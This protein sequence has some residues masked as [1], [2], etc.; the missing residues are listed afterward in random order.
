MDNL[1]A[2]TDVSVR[3][4]KVS[5]LQR[6]VEN[7]QQV[8]Q[9]AVV[10]SG[11]AAYPMIFI[12]RDGPQQLDEVITSVEV[13]ARS[14][15]D[16]QPGSSSS[17]NESASCQHET[18]DQAVTVQDGINSEP[19]ET[20][21]VENVLRMLPSEHSGP[22]SAMEMVQSESADQQGGV[23][24]FNNNRRVISTAICTM[25]IGGSFTIPPKTGI[26]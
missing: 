26:W 1:P 10:S 7:D 8:P 14:A 21:T 16:Q 5:V 15:S 24:D 13:N 23:A 17:V 9:R 12:S 18:V 2:T 11:S 22:A 25:C 19:V 20:P 3:S 4:R 6:V